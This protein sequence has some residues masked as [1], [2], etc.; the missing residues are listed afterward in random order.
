MLDY[1]AHGLGKELQRKT[2]G[3]KRR[4]ER[5]IIPKPEILKFGHLD[6]QLKYFG[7]F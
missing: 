3:G 1:R 4:E 6:S 7:S 2:E 5:R